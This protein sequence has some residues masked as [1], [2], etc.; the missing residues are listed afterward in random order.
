M[1]VC[2]KV[3]LFWEDTGLFIAVSDFGVS[4]KK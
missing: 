2:L 3:A 4:E 1:Y